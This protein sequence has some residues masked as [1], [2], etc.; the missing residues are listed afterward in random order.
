MENAILLESNSNEVSKKNIHYTLLIGGVYIFFSFLSLFSDFFTSTFCLGGCTDSQLLTQRE[1]IPNLGFFILAIIET[2]GLIKRRWWAR[3]FGVVL[4]VLFLARS[5]LFLDSSIASI[6]SLKIKDVQFSDVYTF[7]T[8]LFIITPI[9]LFIPKI[10]GYW[11]YNGLKGLV[12]LATFSF[13]GIFLTVISWQNYFDVDLAATLSVEEFANYVVE[14]PDET[15]NAGALYKNTYFQ[16]RSP[17]KI[18]VSYG[19]PQDMAFLNT[20]SSLVSGFTVLVQV[21]HYDT[22]LDSLEKFSHKY[23]NVSDTISNTYVKI[24]DTQALR[25]E[26]VRAIGRSIEYRIVRKGRFFLFRTLGN[27]PLEQFDSIMSTLKFT[28]S[29]TLK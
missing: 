21:A 7:R 15:I 2:Y 26:K 20:D 13:V 16:F 9:C 6:A 5:F 29:T 24:D 19:G 12:F 8:L 1:F 3:I 4:P 11:K 27:P 25:S 18:S 23:L 10:T 17:I 22:T 28:D 14:L